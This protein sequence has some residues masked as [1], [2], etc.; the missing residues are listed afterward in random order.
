MKR[1]DCHFVIETNYIVMPFCKNIVAQVILVPC[2][3]NLTVEKG[4]SRS[5]GG[6]SQQA[7][8]LQYEEVNV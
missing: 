8:T 6:D 3:I 2:S 1:T 7:A 5:R 4:Q